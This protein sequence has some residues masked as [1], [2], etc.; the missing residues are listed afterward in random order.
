MIDR[1]VLQQKKAHGEEKSKSWRQYLLAFAF[2][3]MDSLVRSKREQGPAQD[4]A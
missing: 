4:V 1:I 2:E 3:Q